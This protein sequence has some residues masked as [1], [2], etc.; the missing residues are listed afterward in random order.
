MASVEERKQLLHGDPD[1]SIVKPHRVFCR[2][3]D[4]W[5]K[6]DEVKLY[7]ASV[8]RCHKNTKSQ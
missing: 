1:I 6:L 5:L 8:W 3:C 4:K 7:A 2:L